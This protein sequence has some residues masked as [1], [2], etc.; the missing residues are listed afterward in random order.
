MSGIEQA[1]LDVVT[2]TYQSRTRIKMAK[3]LKGN[4][5]FPNETYCIRIAEKDS[6]RYTVLARTFQI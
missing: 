3:D 5:T 1:R 2:I 4:Q 6:I